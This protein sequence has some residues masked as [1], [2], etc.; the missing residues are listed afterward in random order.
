[1]LFSLFPYLNFEINKIKQDFSLAISLIQN[2]TQSINVLI[3]DHTKFLYVW[4]FF[5]SANP[6]PSVNSTV[7]L[8][9]RFRKWYPINKI[10]WLLIFYSRWTTI[11]FLTHY[12]PPFLPII[13]ECHQRCPSPSGWVPSSNQHPRGVQPLPGMQIF[14]NQN[15]FHVTETPPK[16]SNLGFLRSFKFV[17]FSNCK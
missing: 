2:Q 15:R 8:A 4:K 14:K 9:A 1:M 10:F 6:N 17:N 16:K 3:I 5:L 7:Q 11:L 13:F 12:C